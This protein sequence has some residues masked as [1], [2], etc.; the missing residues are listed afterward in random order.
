MVRAFRPAPLAVM[1]AGLVAGVAVSASAAPSVSLSPKVNHPSSTVNVS[2]AGF[3]AN[4]GIDL[5]WD[6]TDEMLA[7]S[8]STGA[9]S[10]H[11]IPVPADALP[12][13]H[14]ITAVER[15]SG[16]GAQ[17]AFTVRT[18]WAEHG[19][20]A[21][22]QR[23]NPY[24]N[25]ISPANASSLDVAWTYPTGGIVESSPAVVGGVVYIGSND[26]YL[27]ALNAT[28]GALKWKRNV[29]GVDY[30]SPAV[31]DGVV[32]VGSYTT[33]KFYALNA[34][35]GKVKWFDYMDGAMEGSPTV[36]NGI[37]YIG[38]DNGTLFALYTD[39]G[40]PEWNHPTTAGNA[41]YSAP[42]LA[43]GVVYTG[44][45]DTNLYALDAATGTTVW[46]RKTGDAVYSSPAVA[47]RKIYFGSY[48]K[49]LWALDDDNYPNR[50]PNGGTGGAVFS[51]PAIV[52]GTT[53]VGS[54]DGLLYAVRAGRYS[55]DTVW[56]YGN[57]ANPIDSSPAAANG[58]VYFGV[59]ADQIHSSGYLVALDAASGGLL[60]EGR[61]NDSITSS[62]AVANGMV[63]VGS[64]DHNV[65]AYA[66]NAGAN[67]VYHRNPAPPAFASLHPDLRLRPVR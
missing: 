32:Y 64:Y 28:T 51:S 13:A 4:K 22:G 6:A 63:Y 17:A 9:F 65:Y 23:Y 48:D 42:A 59:V 15:G 16:D 46:T 18:D 36:A 54:Q 67:A 55:C 38:T 37:V 57:S 12:G 41:I 47:N 10:A 34:S 30:S 44:S 29:G 50:C 33:N 52:N 43:G 26:G 62:P 27:Y 58:V 3:G 21:R 60:W 19:F 14:W 1:A 31:A 49:Y 39:T 61:T 20:G 8:D 45:G 2:G 11:S 40:N 7:V 24:E 66:L 5:Y 35:T 25:V 53:Y 56:T